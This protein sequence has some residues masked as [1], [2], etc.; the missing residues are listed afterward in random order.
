MEPIVK[1]WQLK[2][3]NQNWVTLAHL[4]YKNLCISSLDFLLWPIFFL[5]GI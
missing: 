2:K 3:E 5:M 4:F 1:L